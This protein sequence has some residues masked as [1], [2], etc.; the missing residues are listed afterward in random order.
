[1]PLVSGTPYAPTT[2]PVTPS[3]K[4]QYM[5]THTQSTHT[6]D[7][8]VLCKCDPDFT[9]FARG[10]CGIHSLHGLGEGRDYKMRPV[11]EQ[12]GALQPLHNIVWVLAQQHRVEQ[13]W[14]EG[15]GG[16]TVG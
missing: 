5:L 11:G 15:Q 3:A 14:S 8:V 4:Y 12:L 9:D 13:Y 16:R 2:R 7:L 6:V 10:L 1:M